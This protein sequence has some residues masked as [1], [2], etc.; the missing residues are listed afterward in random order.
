VTG[1]A[2]ASLAG[3]TIT[4][5]GSNP[6]GAAAAFSLIY[7]LTGPRGTSG[8]GTIS[9]MVQ[10]LVASTAVIIGQWE[11]NTASCTDSVGGNSGTPGG[12]LA[13]G[14]P[15]MVAGGTGGVSSLGNGYV[16]I[17][18]AA[19][20]NID[21]GAI[22]IYCQPSSLPALT[23]H[24]AIVNRDG[25]GVPNG[26]TMEFF[27]VGGVGKFNGY[28]RND[29]GVGTRF[30]PTTTGLFTMNVGTAYQ[31]TIAFDPAANPQATVRY[32]ASGGSLQSPAG[33]NLTAPATTLAGNIDDILVMIYTGLVTGFVGGVQRLM[34]WN[35]I[36]TD[37]QLNALPAPTSIVVAPPSNDPPLVTTDPLTLALAST[38]TSR[39]INPAQLATNADSATVTVQGFTG[40]VTVAVSTFDSQTITVT[41]V[42]T[43]AT[44]GTINYTLTN[45]DGQTDTGAI[46]HTVAAS[47]GTVTP[48]PFVT[49]IRPSLTAWARPVFNATNPRAGS[50]VDPNSGMEV[51]KLLPDP[52][53]AMIKAP[54]S[55]S[56][57]SGF[58]TLACTRH[59]AAE[60]PTWSRPNGRYLL[61][62]QAHGA[63]GPWPNG[64]VIIR[65][66]DWRIIRFG[67][68]FGSICWWDDQ[69][70]EIMWN[71][72][73]SGNNTVYQTFNVL[74][75]VVA[76]A[77]TISGYTMFYSN[78]AV[79]G[80]WDRGAYNRDM[81]S[82]YQCRCAKRISDGA[83]VLIRINLRNGTKSADIV[84]PND[85]QGANGA[86][87][88]TNG[89]SGFR[90]SATGRYIVASVNGR[91]LQAY[92]VP[93]AGAIPNSN[94]TTLT[95]GVFKS[96][97]DDP[98]GLRHADQGVINGDDI[99]VGIGTGDNLTRWNITA[100]SA[101]ALASL[102]NSGNP[103]TA[104]LQGASDSFALHGAAGG[105]TTGSPRYAVYGKSG[106]FSA[107]GMWAFRMGPSDT[108]VCR[109]LGHPM[110][111]LSGVSGVSSSDEQC[112][113]N[114]DPTGRY[115]VFVS[116]WNLGSSGYNG[117]QSPYIIVLP[118][119]WYSSTNSSA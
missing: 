51:F 76:P 50:R 52:S 102:T 79:E 104:N 17:A 119:G 41:R 25:A 32:K 14:Q 109:Y 91:R 107:G 4:I 77:F 21:A 74:T 24:T 62:A 89:G 30:S 96:E 63:G 71:A 23:A 43:A 15:T 66:S 18:A 90:A 40:N 105:A 70:D 60:I 64:G 65:T 31:I 16:S 93:G 29:A 47:G 114:A 100:N 58:Y 97:T 69:T 13:F 86:T 83:R 75:G 110:C 111:D 117:N 116:S 59:N 61:I 38:D 26:W 48:F 5:T 53:V 68:P 2:T 42:G 22:T 7:S 6:G 55:G 106:S 57:S 94:T 37:A 72:G 46:N 27:N 19:G 85:N 81:R 99:G 112:D 98:L 82:G 54:E 92:N 118:P 9:G 3:D 35:G 20:Y 101:R 36:P 33:V 95:A 49:T 87:F 11:L 39:I 8:P 113:P 67:I 28:F 103:I 34:L 45:P 84:V 80:N 1:P 88:F 73:T 108:N 44:S 10:P 12:A 78:A 56:G 115:I